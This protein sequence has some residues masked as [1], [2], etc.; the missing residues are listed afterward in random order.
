MIG[1]GS[2]TGGNKIG[3]IRGL[4]GLEWISGDY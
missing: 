1:A 3:T 2:A 4:I